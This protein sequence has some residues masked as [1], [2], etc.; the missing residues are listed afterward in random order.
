MEHELTGITQVINDA[1][2]REKQIHG[3]VSPTYSYYERIVLAAK[4]KGYVYQ[5]HSY[6]VHHGGFDGL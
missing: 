2:L 6:I 4:D 3:T 5:L 1:L